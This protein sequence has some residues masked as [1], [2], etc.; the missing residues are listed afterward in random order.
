MI[1]VGEIEI[2]S[3]QQRGCANKRWYPNRKAANRITR[4]MKDQAVRPYKCLFC[5]GY[6]IGHP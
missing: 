6:H 5:D 2:P 4:I 1:A 3:E